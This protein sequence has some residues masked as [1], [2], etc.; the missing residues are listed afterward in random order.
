MTAADLE[1][2]YSVAD[3]AAHDSEY[4]SLLPIEPRA[5]AAQPQQRRSAPKPSSAQTSLCHSPLRG[6]AIFFLAGFFTCFVYQYSHPSFCPRSLDLVDQS[7]SH[8]PQSTDTG[9][10]RQTTPSH[11]G[12]TVVHNYPP[13]S[14]TNAIPSLFPS[15]IGYAGPTPTGAEPAL[16][17]TAPAYPLHEGAP[18]LLVPKPLG[19]GTSSRPGGNFDIA[20]H[21][22]N[23]SPWF[24]V[25]SSSFGLESASPNP[26]ETCSVIGLHLLHRHG[27]RYPTSHAIPEG[28]A[29]F[30]TRL[31]NATLAGKPW[32]ATG[33]L[34]FLNNWT[35]K[36]GA[37]V[38]TTFG[39]HQLLEL[40]IAMRIKYGFLLETFTDRLPV[41]RTESQNRMLQSAY[42]FAIGFFGYPFEDKYLQ[43]ISIEALGFN[44]TLAPYEACP[45]AYDPEKAERGAE[46]AKKWSAIYLEPARQRLQSQIDGFAFGIEDIYTMQK[47]CAYETVAMGYS[48]FCELFTEE[49]WE[50]FAYSLD[51]EFWYT[52]AFGAPLARSLGVGYLQE[53]IARITHTPITTH[54]SS[55]NSTL[56]D[57]P[58]TF[59]L[60]DAL[61][62]DATH[63]TVFL[64]IITALNLTNFAASGPLPVDHIPKKRSF[65]SSELASFATNMQFQLLSCTSTPEPQIRIIINDGV[66][67]L[68]GIAGCPK[69]EHGM[70]PV[71]TFVAAQRKTIRETD[72]DWACHG[73][74]TVPPGA[75]WNTTTGEPPARP[76]A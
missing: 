76:P 66:T 39:R 55:T 10:Y 56:D 44:N 20:K 60:N 24:S 73:D 61:Y 69:N 34:S 62:V 42:N 71:P 45:N 52:A 17:A 25:P 70:C 48:R 3:D 16:V 28:P 65:S 26:P 8:L 72:W 58:T 29:L 43:S 53:L 51:L 46:Y 59:P 75:A 14:P 57:N 32:V 35:Y 64:H 4:H 68:S 36:L 33:S 31:H 50:G 6:Y 2:Q 40:G 18:N 37:A 22:G 41:F 74:W 54:N 67:P 9:T 23:L 19:H 27:A 38:L 5:A 47:L 49:E 30:A 12:S 13:A 21:W 11:A 7:Y 1:R 15:N 63:E